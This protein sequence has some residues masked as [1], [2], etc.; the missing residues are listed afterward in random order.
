MDGA[1]TAPVADL[2]QRVRY[3]E[4]AVENLATCA[5]LARVE[6]RL[7]ATAE[8][9]RLYIERKDFHNADLDT[10]VGQVENTVT[11]LRVQMA[12]IGAVGTV[13]L[14][15]VVGLVTGLIR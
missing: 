11:A 2:A 13:L 4:S 12:L 6:E 3:L 8:V 5:D 14:G 7:A 1:K 15:A 9:M 10:R